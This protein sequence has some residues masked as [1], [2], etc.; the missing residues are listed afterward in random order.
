MECSRDKENPMII[1]IQINN[2]G[3]PGVATMAGSE[4]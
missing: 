1:T 2:H 4:N 3:K